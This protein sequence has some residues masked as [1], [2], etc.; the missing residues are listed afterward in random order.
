MWMHGVSALGP[1]LFSREIGG[2]I[3]GWCAYARLAPRDV[4][5]LTWN[6]GGSVAVQFWEKLYDGSASPDL[7][8]RFSENFDSGPNEISVSL[9]VKTDSVQWNIVERDEAKK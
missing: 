1:N 3:S 2:L 4:Q 5:E 9:V 6:H 7:L 8:A